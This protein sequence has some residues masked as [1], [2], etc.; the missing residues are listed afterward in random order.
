MD[1]EDAFFDSQEEIETSLLTRKETGVR[2]RLPHLMSLSS[3]KELNEPI[4]QEP[5]P[6][7]EDIVY[8]HQEILSR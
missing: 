6:L 1:D 3:K 5:L 8:Q 7:T 4:V 2:C